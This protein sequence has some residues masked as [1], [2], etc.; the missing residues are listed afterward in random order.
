MSYEAA[1]PEK[2]LS[3]GSLLVTE[4]NNGVILLSNGNYLHTGLHQ[5]Q[6]FQTRILSRSR[7]LV[8]NYCHQMVSHQAYLF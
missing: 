3:S 7:Q 4:P 5:S 2:T 1:A 6:Q 8:H